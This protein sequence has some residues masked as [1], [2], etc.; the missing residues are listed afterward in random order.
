MFIL[1]HLPNLASVET[2]LGCDSH[3]IRVMKAYHLA[4]ALHPSDLPNWLFDERERKPSPS[5]GFMGSSR[6]AVPDVQPPISFSHIYD[7]AALRAPQVSHS[8]TAS[9]V[10]PS[11]DKAGPSKATNRP[12]TLRDAKRPYLGVQH[13]FSKSESSSY[14]SSRIHT[15]VDSVYGVDCGDASSFPTRRALHSVQQPRPGAF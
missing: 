2:S 13:V 12:K 5:S 14:S 8:R 15:G 3:L 4:K 11:S 6:S 1:S 10:L 7:E 9:P